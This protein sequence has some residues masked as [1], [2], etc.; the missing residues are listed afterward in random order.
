[1]GEKYKR[2]KFFCTSV[3]INLSLG[4]SIHCYAPT[5][6]SNENVKEEFY[7]R[8]STI[9][10]NCP[11]QNMTIMM[12]NFNAKIGSDER[13]HEKTTGQHGLGETNNNG[14]RF[15]DLRALSNLV[16]GGSVFQD[17]RIHKATLVSPN[18]S[19]EN[20]IDH[21]CIGRKSRRFL[22]EVCVKCGADVASDHHLLIA[23][24]KFKLK[25]NW[26]GDSYQRLP[27]NTTMLLNTIKQQDFK[28]ALLN[29]FQ[30][31]EELL[32]EDTI[33]VK[34]QAIKE[35][36]TS[37][38]KEVLGPKKQNHHEWITAETL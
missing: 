7:S 19:T 24:L 37:T 2:C 27:Y 5:N 20:Q 17:K 29:K 4:Q 6:D 18:L 9:T 14:E 1:M 13:G 32:E 36:F 35:S 23:K 34:W 26:K 12:G 16:I 33:N 11:R 25:R 21:V 15:A 10:Q 22:Q 8:L 28:T 30:V 3:T 38:C 31:L